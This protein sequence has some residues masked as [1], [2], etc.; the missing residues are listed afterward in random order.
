MLYYLG[1]GVVIMFIVELLT[2]NY[3]EERE[4]LGEDVPKFNWFD[5]IFNI[6][7]WPIT[8]LIFIKNIHKLF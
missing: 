5:R 4:Y 8:V 2:E 6:L 3:R 7:L 1:I